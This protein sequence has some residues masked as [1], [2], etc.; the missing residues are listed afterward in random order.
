MNSEK[1]YYYNKSLQKKE[2]SDSTPKKAIILSHLGLGDNV[3]LT[4]LA[5]FL[6][7]YYEEVQ[8]ICKE[9][10]LE[11]VK[12]F[13]HSDENIVCIPVRANGGPEDISQIDEIIR[14][15]YSDKDVYI[16]GF[17]HTNRLS[18]QIKHPKILEYQQLEKNNTNYD[19]FYDSMDYSFIKN[20][21]NDLKIG[22]DIYFEYFRIDTTEISLKL[23]DMVKNYRIIFL[24]INCSSQGQK[25]KID[26]L[27]EK[28]LNNDKVILI[29]T[30]E[31]LY[32]K[33]IYPTKHEICNNFIFKK[34]VNYIDVI[35][36]SDE[37]YV[38]DSCFSCII[39]PLKKLGLLKADP[40]RIIYREKFDNYVF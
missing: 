28:Y 5:R 34:L 6:L 24:Q 11:N 2:I 3:A 10:Y 35:I 39:F 25:L 21:Y 13:F 4:S 19:F 37:I 20:F 16:S 22:A 17:C 40:F 26:G 8:F 1:N 38:T 12:E 30:S 9:Y 29:C 36:N 18:S 31:N 23:Y 15:S 33:E 14:N 32:D 27:K 7:N